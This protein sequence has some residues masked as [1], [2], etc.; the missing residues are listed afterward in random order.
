MHRPGVCRVCRCDIYDWSLHP[1]VSACFASLQT[2]QW[3]LGLSAKFFRLS[4]NNFNS[5]GNITASIFTAGNTH[6]FPQSLAVVPLKV[7]S[8][9]VWN[10][11]T[12]VCG[13]SLVLESGFVER[14]TAVVFFKCIIWYHKPSGSILLER[15]RTSLQLISPKHQTMQMV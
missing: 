12:K 15:R 1:L 4:W 8:A 11:N 5:R 6:V 13:L 3:S 2:E 14:D 9:I 7:A 10:K